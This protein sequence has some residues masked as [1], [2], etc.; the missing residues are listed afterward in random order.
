MISNAYVSG[1][2]GV[3]DEEMAVVLIPGED[4][5]GGGGWEL[6]DVALTL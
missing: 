4:E 5:D 6:R 2:G 3:G 1:D